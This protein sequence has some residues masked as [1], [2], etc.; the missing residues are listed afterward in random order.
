MG[1]I[2]SREVVGVDG[3]DLHGE[4]EG[5]NE[6]SACE[7]EGN[8]EPILRASD[9]F[10]AGGDCGETACHINGEQLVA[11][12]AAIG[13]NRSGHQRQRHSLIHH[14]VSAHITPQG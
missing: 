1:H 8:E 7:V 6:G 13:K 9:V 3:V 5:R 11:D 14:A 10:D 12:R 4:L 2:N